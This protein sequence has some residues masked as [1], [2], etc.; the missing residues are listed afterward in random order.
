MPFSNDSNE[1]LIWTDSKHLRAHHTFQAT[2][3][4]FLANHIGK[5]Q[6]WRPLSLRVTLPDN[7][8]SALPIVDALCDRL[9]WCLS[10]AL[11]FSLDRERTSTPRNSASV[12]LGIAMFIIEALHKPY[13]LGI[14]YLLELS[15][16]TLTAKQYV[17]LAVRK[18]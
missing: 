16:A 12:L 2:I 7:R 11:R 10:T 15:L 13:C 17:T 4:I 9:I 18:I 6:S 3:I 1:L 14:R 8:A 5:P